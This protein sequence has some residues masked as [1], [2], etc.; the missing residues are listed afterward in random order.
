[1]V[2]PMLAGRPIETAAALHSFRKSRRFTP[3]AGDET[4]SRIQ[5]PMRAPPLVSTD[6]KELGICL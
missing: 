1:M 6:E 3:L 4:K 2:A 5:P